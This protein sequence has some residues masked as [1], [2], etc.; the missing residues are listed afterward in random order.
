M[1]THT[2]RSL[3]VHTE[4]SLSEFARLHTA[5]APTLQ[6][7]KHVQDTDP[8]KRSFERLEGAPA[9]PTFAALES[10]LTTGW[11]QGAEALRDLAG[12]L[13]ASIRPPTGRRW[14][15]TPAPVGHTPRIGA[16]L[17]GDYSRAWTALRRLPAPCAGKTVD[18]FA[19]WNA[20][21]GST[22]HELWYQG[23]VPLVVAEALSAAGYSVRLVAC[24]LKDWAM[25]GGGIARQDVVLADAGEPIRVDALAGVLCHGVPARAARWRMDCT[26]PWDVEGFGKPIDSFASAPT[27]LRPADGAVALRAVYSHD[28]AVREIK[29]ALESAGVEV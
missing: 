10:L 4:R 25:H 8:A 2:N 7:A 9:V 16:L 11:P 13:S 27:D 6:N 14:Q 20:P 15:R 26:L 19:V 12:T 24:S 1:K 3:A 28:S 5:E 17:A 29:R 18:V 23:A 22:A 21:N